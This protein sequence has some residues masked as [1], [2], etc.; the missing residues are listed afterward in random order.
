MVLEIRSIGDRQDVVTY[1]DLLINA[2][3]TDTKL[4]HLKGSTH[5]MGPTSG[6]AIRSPNLCLRIT[7]S[8]S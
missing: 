1:V 3:T 8:F 6:V 5:L 4:T 2:E 7:E